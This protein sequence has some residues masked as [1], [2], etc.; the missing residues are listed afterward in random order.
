LSQCAGKPSLTHV[1]IQGGVGGLAAAINAYLWQQMGK[2][3]PSVIVVE[4]RLADCLYQ[5][6]VMRSP[7]VVDITDETLMAGL[8]CGEVSQLAWL[9]L[10]AGASDFLTI[11]EELVAPTMRLLAGLDKKII[12]GESAI[13]GLAAL[14]GVSMQHDLSKS[15]G[16]NESSR[17]L[18]LGTEGATDPEIYQQL[19]GINPG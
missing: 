11:D 4:P 3:M 8:S 14:L 9:I 2:A 13:A 6:A 16:L 12:A 17:V 10:E 1:F 5:S 18:V 7:T 15:L 19:T